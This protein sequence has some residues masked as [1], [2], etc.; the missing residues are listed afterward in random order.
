M[1]VRNKQIP[2]GNQTYLY[3]LCWN[4]DFQMTVQYAIILGQQKTQY[5]MTMA[6]VVI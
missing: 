2:H 1:V 4:Y 6:I 5:S 3:N